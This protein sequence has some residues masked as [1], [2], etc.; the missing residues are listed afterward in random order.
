MIDA[1]TA[2]LARLYRQLQAENNEVMRLEREMR[3]S[4][5]PAIKQRWLKARQR[6]RE[7]NVELLRRLVDLQL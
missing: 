1:T 7:A 2:E 5:D 4:A 3:S 6:R